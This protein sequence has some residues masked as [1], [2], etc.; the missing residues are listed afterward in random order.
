VP[1]PSRIDDADFLAAKMLLRVHAELAERGFETTIA[2]LDSRP[3]AALAPYPAKT[4]ASP[5]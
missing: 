2:T 5:L 3:H 1:D 4:P